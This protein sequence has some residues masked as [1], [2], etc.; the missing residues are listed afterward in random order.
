MAVATLDISWIRIVPATESIGL[1]TTEDFIRP[2]IYDMDRRLVK[3]LIGE[4]INIDGDPAHEYS[5]DEIDFLEGRMGFIP[6]VLEI[7]L[8]VDPDVVD[9]IKTEYTAGEAFFTFGR[10]KK[11]IRY[12]NPANDSG[13]TG[14]PVVM[15][16]PLADV[17]TFASYD[18]IDLKRDL[19]HYTSQDEYLR[20]RYYN[21]FSEDVNERLLAYLGNQVLD[22]EISANSAEKKT[23]RSK[24][25]EL[26]RK[27]YDMNR[28]FSRLEDKISEKPYLTPKKGRILVTRQAIIQKFNQL[29]VGFS[30]MPLDLLFGALNK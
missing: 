21:S 28:F 26:D 23:T 15:G 25:S 6:A 12:E 8:P 4:R 27:I 24:V 29:G 18:A 7:T 16:C 30:D 13:F 20:N 10:G 1:L 9:G 11:V 5:T 19:E 17:R 2:L 22:E 3:L 14:D